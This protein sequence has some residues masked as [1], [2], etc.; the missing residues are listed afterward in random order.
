MPFDGFVENTQVTER[1]VIGRARIEAGW[2]QGHLSR[3]RWSW[4]VGKYYEYCLV[5]AVRKGL[6]GWHPELPDMVYDL[7]QAAIAYLGYGGL[8]HVFNDSTERTKAQV[9]EV[10]DLAIAMSRGGKQ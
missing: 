5:G 4:R 1:L 3:S 7:I 10:L 2:C 8:P 6:P 9:L